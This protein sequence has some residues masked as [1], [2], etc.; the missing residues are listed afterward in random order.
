MCAAA[1]GCG[2]SPEIWSRVGPHDARTVSWV[3]LNGLTPTE[4]E[5]FSDVGGCLE[6]EKETHFLV[7]LEFVNS[8]SLECLSFSYV[9][10]FPPTP[11]Y[12]GCSPIL[13][14]LLRNRQ[15]PCCL[16]LTQVPVNTHARVSA[17][18]SHACPSFSNCTFAHSSCTVPEFDPR[19]MFGKTSTPN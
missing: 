16:R 11:S 4:P 18:K 3:H 8:S 14:H 5:R 13:C 7:S 17:H 15:P 12:I 6:K 1:Q 9:K 10:G 2:I 19:K